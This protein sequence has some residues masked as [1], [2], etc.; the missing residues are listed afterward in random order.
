MSDSTLSAECND[1]GIQFD[2]LDLTRAL[3]D[4]NAGSK[5]FPRE[6]A[7]SPLGKVSVPAE[8]HRLGGAMLVLRRKRMSD[9]DSSSSGLNECGSLSTVISSGGGGRLS[10]SP[11]P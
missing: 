7:F 6:R 2:D 9:W 5:L 1:R 10:S 11:S 4:S 8:C 3:R